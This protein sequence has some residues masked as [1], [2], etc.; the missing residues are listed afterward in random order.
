MIPYDIN[1]TIHRYRRHNSCVPGGFIFRT[2]HISFKS[3]ESVAR[4]GDSW[5]YHPKTRVIIIFTDVTQSF[6]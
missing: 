3:H 4:S 2:E 1:M 5:P 6:L